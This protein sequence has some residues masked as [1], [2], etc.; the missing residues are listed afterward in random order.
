MCA[1]CGCSNES[2][3]KVFNLQTGHSVSV[4]N[5][6]E[7][8]DEH[9][10]SR[11][12]HSHEDHH[13]HSDHVHEDGHDHGHTHDHNHDHKQATIVTLEEKILAKNDL[14]AARNRGW[15]EGMNI[16]AFNL[17]SAPGA[18]KTAIL[19]RTIKDLHKEISISVVEG[20]QATL[21]DAERIKKA[22]CPVVQINTGAGCHLDAQMI[23]AG[24]KQLNPPRDSVLFIENVGNLVCPAL[25]DL[26]EKS[27]I[28]ILSITEGEDKPVKYPHM[29][30]AAELLLLNKVDLMPH[31]DF[32]IEACKQYALSV[33][34]KLKIIEVS[35]RNGDGLETWY[36]WIRIQ[37]KLAE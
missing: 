5:N 9:D 16:L 18:G 36:Q 21:N 6:Q 20:D 4:M 10:H 8:N 3:P 35:A 17:V 14:L 11:H 25:F 28:V 1:T 26:G 37:K 31:L 23:S 22:G 33:N 30:R 12:D 19:E 15:L 27:K 32:D 29:F 34:P 24:F 13:S 7:I 2:K